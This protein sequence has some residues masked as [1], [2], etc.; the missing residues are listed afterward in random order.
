[1]DVGTPSTPVSGWDRLLQGEPVLPEVKSEVE[2]GLA[3]FG[4]KKTILLDRLQV[5]ACVGWLPGLSQPVKLFDGQAAWRRLTDLAAM[6]F[7]WQAMPSARERVKGLRK[8]AKALDQVCSVAEEV[9]QGNVG[10]EQA[11][12]R[13]IGLFCNLR[14]R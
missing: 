5:A 6:Y 1:M 8:L 12:G 9:M 14:A 2:A 3:D 10:S 11:S 7:L 4:K 13:F